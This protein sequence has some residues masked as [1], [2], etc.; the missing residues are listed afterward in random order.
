MHCPSPR[1]LSSAVSSFLVSFTAY[2]TEKILKSSSHNRY[3]VQR[4]KGQATASSIT[5]AC[6]VN[7]VV[8][9]RPEQRLVTDRTFSGPIYIVRAQQEGKVEEHGQ[10][11]DPSSLAKPSLPGKGSV[12]WRAPAL[13]TDAPQMQQPKNKLGL[14]DYKPLWKKPGTFRSGQEPEG[15]LFKIT[16]AKTNKRH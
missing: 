7:L 3:K 9:Q 2:Q 8:S 16:E 14:K 4:L 6:I 15:N 10:I 13:P 11:R 5:H 1:V 12:W